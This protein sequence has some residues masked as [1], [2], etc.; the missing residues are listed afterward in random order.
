MSEH[1]D[2]SSLADAS[3]PN[4]GRIYDFLLGGNHNF[5]VDR[6]AAQ[7]VIQIAPFM[8]KMV[9]LIRWQLGEATRRLLELGYT[10]FLD[11]ASGL[12]TLDHIHQVSPEGTKV[13]YSDK[14]PVTV[15][16]ARQIIGDNPNIRYLEGTAE[17]PERVLGAPEIETLF[18]NDRDLAIGFN[19]IAWF[20]TDETIDKFASTLYEWSGPNARL[21]LCDVDGAN[22]TDELRTFADIYA[23]MGQPLHLR[24]NE[25]LQELIKPWKVDEPGFLA[26]EKWIGLSGDQQSDANE[27][28]TAGEG[29]GTLGAI[30]RK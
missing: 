7:R 18:G 21:F 20:V 30:L 2:Q 17:E 25:R 13:I 11:F 6:Q 1:P 3:Q 22:L 23:K 8:P 4:A 10:K 24:P 5:E 12:P 9:R 27:T 19:G 16:Y 29:A 15:S 26:L 14:D 28:F